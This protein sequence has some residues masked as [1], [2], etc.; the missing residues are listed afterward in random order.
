MRGVYYCNC[1][2]LCSPATAAAAVNAAAATAATAAAATADSSFANCKFFLH[3]TQ[4]G[5]CPFLH[6]FNFVCV[7]NSPKNPS[8][9]IQFSTTYTE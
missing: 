9:T 2:W 1:C 8:E 4:F 6:L 7:T 3:S 5:R